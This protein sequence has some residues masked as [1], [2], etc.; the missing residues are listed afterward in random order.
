MLC[1]PSTESSP[2]ERIA[3]TKLKEEKGEISGSELDNKKLRL[4]Q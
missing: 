2:W 1:V 3:V 4:K